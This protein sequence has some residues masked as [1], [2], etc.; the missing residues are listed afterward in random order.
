MKNSSAQNSSWGYWKFLLE[1]QL[2]GVEPLKKQTGIFTEDKK[3]LLN[4]LKI[5]W[6]HNAIIIFF[7]V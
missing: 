5:V 6:W 3:L 7:H 2:C 4:P 1:K